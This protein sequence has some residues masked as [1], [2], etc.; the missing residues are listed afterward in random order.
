MVCGSLFGGAQLEF[1][2]MPY[3]PHIFGGQKEAQLHLLPSFEVYR[4]TTRLPCRGGMHAT[5]L[6]VS[7]SARA[8]EQV[9]SDHAPV[10]GDF[11]FLGS[12][13]AALREG[14]KSVA[15]ESVGELSASARS[16]SAP[17]MGGMGGFGAAADVLPPDME[18][19]MPQALIDPRYHHTWIE[20]SSALLHL[21]LF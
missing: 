12:S 16:R 17:G 19:Q 21:H 5:S 13:K 20:P 14:D 3:G 7:A 4:A 10:V 11:V 9:P 15:G 2:R 18:A 1:I 6:T 8:V